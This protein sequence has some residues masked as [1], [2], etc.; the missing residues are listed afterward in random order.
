MNEVPL[1]VTWPEQKERFARL[2]EAIEVI[3]RLWTEERLTYKGAYPV[4][5][6][7]RS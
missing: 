3:R 7:N 6:A 1:G 2:R 5:G 4:P